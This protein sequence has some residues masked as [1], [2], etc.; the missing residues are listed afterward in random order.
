MYGSI[1]VQTQL[2]ALQLLPMN[3]TKIWK[4]GIKICLRL[5]CIPQ[6]FL[7]KSSYAKR[8]AHRR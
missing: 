3:V 7:D 6:Y 2:Y 5:Q 4:A 8:K 1:N